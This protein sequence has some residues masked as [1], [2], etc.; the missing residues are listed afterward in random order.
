[1]FEWLKKLFKKE[2]VQEEVEIERVP[3]EKIDISEPLLKSDETL[4]PPETRYTEEYAEFVET[5]NS[6]DKSIPARMNTEENVTKESGVVPDIRYTPEYAAFVESQMQQG[7]H[8]SEEDMPL[9]PLDKPVDRMIEDE[10]E[11]SFEED[12]YEGETS[13]YE[14]MLE[15]LDEEDI[16]DSEDSGYEAMMKDE[17]IDEDA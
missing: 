8:V 11:G 16:N 17:N 6:D 1:M 5:Q 15:P 12:I 7:I 2:E 13:V 10:E 14:T 9:S 4:T 3:L